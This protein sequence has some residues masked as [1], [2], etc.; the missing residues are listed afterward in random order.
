MPIST[1]EQRR[2]QRD[3]RRR[4]GDSTRPEPAITDTVDVGRQLATMP[5][6]PIC[7]TIAAVTC[8]F[9]PSQSTS[10]EIC[11]RTFSR[12]FPKIGLALWTAEGSFDDRWFVPAG[13]RVVSYRL[14]SRSILFT[15][16]NLLNLIIARLPDRYDRVLWIDADVILLAPDYADR[17]GSELHTHRVVQGF[18]ELAYLSQDFRVITPWRR[19]LAKV[20]CEN[21][22]K[23]SDPAKA[24][25][26]LIWGADRQML[27][28]IGGLYDRVIVGGGDV[29]W[30]SAIYDPVVSQYVQRW[31]AKL[32]AEIREWG[33]R[34]RPL[35]PSVGYVP[36]RGVHLWHGSL[37]HRQYVQRNLLLRNLD[38]DPR[39]H[40]EY[41]PNGTLRWSPAAPQALRDGIAEYMHSRREDGK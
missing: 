35:V 17:L 22:T 14:D 32:T 40:L 9:N 5:Y 25:P 15:K 39:F 38:F 28:E 1:R 21:R 16:E 20:N 10:R 29:A 33:N 27:C 8:Y 13:R 2:R 11:Y 4:H 23:T 18:S 30:A 41:A 3:A 6:H 34:V 31:P 37:R 7:Q 24:Y 12:Q 36:A 26:G 19:S